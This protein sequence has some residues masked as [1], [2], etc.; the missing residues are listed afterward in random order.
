M[1]Y[2]YFAKGMNVLTTLV[3]QLPARD[4]ALTSAQW[5][6]SALPF[7]LFDRRARVL[8]VGQSSLALLPKAR[9]TILLVA[10]RDVL[11]LT[12]ALAPLKGARLQQALPHV[13]EEHVIG[14]PQTCHIALDPSAVENN[15]R[16]LATIDRAWFRFVYEAFIEAGHHTLRAV[17]ITRCLAIPEIA[18]TASLEAKL[19]SAAEQKAAPLLAMMVGYSE[20]SVATSPT[21][22]AEPCVE[23]ALLRAGLGQGLT[24]PISALNETLSA[25]AAPGPLTLYQLTDVP[26]MPSAA[27]LPLLPP[28]AQQP[29]LSFESLA[30]QALGCPFNLCQFEFAQQPWRF[31]RGALK[32]WRLP[33]GLALAS[34]LAMIIGVNLQWLL[35]VRQQNLLSTQQIEVL[36]SAFP[37][38]AVVL[39]PPQQMTRQLDA[40]RT[41][42]GEL[43]PTDFLSLAEGLARSLGPIAP[44]AIAQMDYRNR[45]L[46]VSFKPNVKIDEAFGQ[47]LASQGL[48]AHFAQGKW[49]IKGRG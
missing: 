24:V 17:P 20:L 37:K 42:V 29:S 1:Q 15:Q 43:S 48:D 45:A 2:D 23:L 4:P 44:T 40:L 28:F 30:R 19:E 35:L 8:R 39:N 25:L 11:M 7:I 5:Q 10:A 47:R 3:V 36:M 27:A 41:A 6:L 38:T 22:V 13:I 33:V 32:H 26:G 9:A 34:V 12:V 31:K 18:D 21:D 49:M 14:D 46:E 16:V